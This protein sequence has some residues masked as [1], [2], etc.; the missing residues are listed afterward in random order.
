MVYYLN[1]LCSK[2]N[3][4]SS[5]LVWRLTI[6]FNLEI[7]NK[8]Q[9]KCLRIMNFP[10]FWD[11]T[12]DLFITNKIIKFSDI[13]ITNQIKLIHQYNKKAL[14]TDLHNLF[15]HGINTHNYNTRI[16]SNHRLHIPQVR[17]QS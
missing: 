6:Q 13:I 1:S 15:I 2:I 16:S 17:S 8:L 14:P 10:G 5:V 7:I 4:D 9:K 3:N 12:N 11:H